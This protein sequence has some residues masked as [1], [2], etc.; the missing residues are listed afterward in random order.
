MD[1]VNTDDKELYEVDTRRIYYSIKVMIIRSITYTIN[2]DKIESLD[3]QKIVQARID[4]I[5]SEFEKDQIKIRTVRFNT[6]LIDLNHELSSRLSTKIIESSPIISTMR[7]KV[8]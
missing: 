2:L 6:T 1:L 7:C 5:R 3:Y 8:V 4:R